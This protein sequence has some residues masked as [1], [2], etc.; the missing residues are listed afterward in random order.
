QKRIT[1]ISLEQK[2]FMSGSNIREAAD[3]K[4]VIA[5][6]KSSL[7]TINGN[8]APVAEKSQKKGKEVLKR[9]TETVG[10]D[11]QLTLWS[12]NYDHDDYQWLPAEFRNHFSFGN[13]C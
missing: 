7:F 3:L 13:V 1:K 11:L 12:T 10:A 9:L 6:G 5:T 8:I 2:M 4:D